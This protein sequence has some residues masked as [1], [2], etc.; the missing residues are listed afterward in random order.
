MD[1]DYIITK[2]IAI[3]GVLVQKIVA[4][5]EMVELS[6]EI[7][8]DLRGIGSHENIVEEM[9]DVSVMFK[10]LKKMYNVTDAEL[11]KEIEYK[12][13]RLNARLGDWSD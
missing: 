4:I 12:L 13:A 2:A 8:K 7:S 10:Q 9:A 5:E 1:Q 6:K 3:N 11:E